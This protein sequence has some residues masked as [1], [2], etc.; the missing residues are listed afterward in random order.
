MIKVTEFETVEIMNKPVQRFYEDEEHV[1]YYKRAD[2]NKIADITGTMITY[3]IEPLKVA[4]TGT[5]YGYEVY[6]SQLDA[7]KLQEYRLKWNTRAML[8]QIINYD[9]NLRRA[10]ENESI[11]SK[12]E[13]AEALK[14]A[15]C[16]FIDE[17]I[18]DGE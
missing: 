2:L 5:G 16:T 6:I 11:A 10:Q 14:L 7:L 15:F 17:F 8:E 13:K 3:G 12:Q 9:E 18:K 1:Y 4:A